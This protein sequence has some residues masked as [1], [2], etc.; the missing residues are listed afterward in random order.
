MD[1]LTTYTYDSELQAITAPPLI[2]TIHKSQQHP[3]SLFQP[4]VSSPAVPWQRLLTVDILQ[5]HA[6]R[7]TK[8]FLYFKFEGLMAM[9]MMTTAG[10]KLSSCL[11]HTSSGVLFGLLFNPEDGSN[12]FL[13]LVRIFELHG[14]TTQKTVLF[15]IQFVQK[16]S[17]PWS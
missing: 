8:D 17:L 7:S 12:T 3:L 16:G 4:A 15:D 2:S 6:L 11:T 10:E 13:E 14:A 1:L 5:L 9:T